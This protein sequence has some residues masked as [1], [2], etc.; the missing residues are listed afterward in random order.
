MSA[1]HARGQRKKSKSGRART[2]TRG[3]RDEC[4]ARVKSQTNTCNKNR[5]GYKKQRRLKININLHSSTLKL[6]LF[7]TDSFLT[8]TNNAFFCWSCGRRQHFLFCWEPLPQIC[9]FSRPSQSGILKC[10]ILSFP[11]PRRIHYFDSLREGER[12]GGVWGVGVGNTCSSFSPDV[13]NWADVSSSQIH[14]LCFL[15]LMESMRTEAQF[16]RQDQWIK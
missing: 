10:I 2:H 16:L 1:R 8:I 12:K 13:E 6:V 11:L 7:S 15:M 5:R 3:E 14:S 4:V 9:S